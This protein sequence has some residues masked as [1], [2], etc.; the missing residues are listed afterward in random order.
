MVRSIVTRVLPCR[1]EQ[2]WTSI[3]ARVAGGRRSE[4]YDEA[5]SV[6]SK[7]WGL[8]YC[9][10]RVRKVTVR[11][12]AREERAYLQ[13][14]IAQNSYAPSPHFKLSITSSID[15]TCMSSLEFPSENQRVIA[16]SW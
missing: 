6:T 8:E 15:S 10:F 9:N 14:C 12:Q 4:G 16:V 1:D 3:R 5:D 7:Q 2:F 13:M 11:R